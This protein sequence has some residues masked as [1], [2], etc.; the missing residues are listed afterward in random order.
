M[1]MVAMMTDSCQ[2]DCGAIGCPLARHL[3]DSDHIPPADGLCRRFGIGCG[4][5]ALAD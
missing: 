2:S 5:E 3:L 1:M 4:A